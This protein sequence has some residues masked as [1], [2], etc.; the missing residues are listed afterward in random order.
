MA[1]DLTPTPT[2]SSDELRQVLA[3]ERP[4]PNLFKY[5]VLASLLFGPIFF[6]PLVVLYFR[7]HT[8]RYRFDEQGVQMRWGILFRREVSLAYAR[9]Q[10]IHLTSNLIE[11]WFGLARIQISTA[12]GASS[13]EMTIEGLLEFELVRDFLYAKMRGGHGA[14][15]AHRTPLQT[16]PLGAPLGSGSTVDS[17]ALIAAL[18]QVSEDLRAVREAL[19]RNSR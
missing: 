7:Y 3:I 15:A 6:V 16:A 18:Q 19:E 5:Y 17:A 9:I 1:H 13:A 11:R 12:S 10:D 14:N 2:H 4:H 8:M